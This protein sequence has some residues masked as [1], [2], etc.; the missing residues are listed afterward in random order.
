MPQKYLQ[1]YLHS[2]EKETDINLTPQSSYKTIE[3]NK[4]EGHFKNNVRM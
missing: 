4:R 2:Y 3:R 1:A